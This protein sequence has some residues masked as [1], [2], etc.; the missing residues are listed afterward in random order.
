MIFEKAYFS[1]KHNEQT[2]VNANGLR[3]TTMVL[4]ELLG[5]KIFLAL[6]NGVSFFLG[7][8]LI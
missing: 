8:Q 2:P 6:K 3:A 5:S 1:R 4:L 7:T